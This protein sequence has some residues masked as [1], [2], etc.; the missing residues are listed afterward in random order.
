[1]RT[2]M[3][4]A[5]GVSAGVGV[6]TLAM[7]GFGVPGGDVATQISKLGYDAIGDLTIF[8][9]GYAGLALFFTGLVLMV[10]ANAGA[11]KETGGY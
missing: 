4:V 3:L 10:A 5:G 9:S 6:M 2:V 8:P 1:M 7:G 11:Y